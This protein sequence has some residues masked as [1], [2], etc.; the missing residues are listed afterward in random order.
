[1][2]SEGLSVRPLEVAFRRDGSEMDNLAVE[3]KKNARTGNY[4][5]PSPT[6]RARAVYH[7][8][9]LSVR[10]LAYLSKNLSRSFVSTAMSDRYRLVCS[11]FQRSRVRR[12][13]TNRM[14]GRFEVPHKG[15]KILTYPRRKMEKV[16]RDSC[17]IS[18]VIKGSE[19]ERGEG[20]LNVSRLR[21]A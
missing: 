5:V 16:S 10:A 9:S 8:P 14:E 21:G 15:S 6:H 11:A 18:S 4:P 2:A 1:M 13:S 3:S 7:E 19:A 17:P 12:R 20:I